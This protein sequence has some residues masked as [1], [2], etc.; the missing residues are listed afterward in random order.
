M[1]AYDKNVHTNI[2]IS[3]GFVETIWLLHVEI[4]RGEFLVSHLARTDN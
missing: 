4:L 1:L 3:L 2:L